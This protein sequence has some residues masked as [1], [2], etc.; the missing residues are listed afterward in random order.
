MKKILKA[1]DEALRFIKYNVGNE[2][3]F[4]F[5]HD[6]WLNGAPL[7]KQDN[8]QITSLADSDAFSKVKSFIDNKQWQPTSSN[9]QRPVLS[10]HA[11]MIEFRVHI[12]S[13]NIHPSDSIAGMSLFLLD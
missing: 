12:P 10:N 5:S 6:L 8:Q 7:L 1:R 9:Y 2:S 4:L 3:E 13:V 11:V